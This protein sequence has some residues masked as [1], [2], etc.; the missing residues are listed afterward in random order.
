MVN[1]CD[2]IHHGLKESVLKPWQR[3]SAA[4]V[5]MVLILSL[6][7][8]VVSA[9]PGITVTNAGI[10]ATVSPGQ[11][12]TEKMTVSIGNSDPATDVSV[13]V[14]GVAQS[15]TGGYILLDPAQDTNQDT[16][17]SFVTVDPS[18]F[19]LD[20]GQSQDIT[21]IVTVPQNVGSG[22]YFA[23]INIAEPPTTTSDSNVAIVYSVG[24][25]VFLTIK[26]SQLNQ[27]GTIT[28]ITAGTI[29]NGQPINITTTFQNTGNIYFKVEGQTTITNDQGVMLDT[30]PMPLTSSSIIPGMSRDLNATFTP[31]GSLAPGTYT[32]RSVVMSSDSILLD[33]S[34]GTFTIK[35][36]YKPPPALG[37][38]SLAPSGASTLKT[39]TGNISVYFPV[40]AAAIPVD[41]S[42]NNITAAQLPVAPDGYGFTGT[43]FQ[44]NGLTGL[45][46][47][48]ATVTVQ[49]TPDD[50]SKAGGKPSSLVLTRWDPGTNKWVVLKT[51]ANAKAMTLSANSK[52]LGIMAVASSLLPS[53]GI[54]WIIIGPIVAV[55]IVIAIM[56][57]LLIARRKRVKP[58]KR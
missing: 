39:T 52:Q 13:T 46:A 10:V 26:G 5:M 53:S 24:V 50:L 23:L 16:A 45:L 1:K 36:P 7:P 29:T 44:V 6:I 40:G 54:N 4:V 47:K 58:V 55:V 34:D 17:R 33:K 22:G 8:I 56:G 57:I 21:A 2:T 15:S 30:I 3:R 37:T 51:K 38:V 18:A 27:T 11:V 12:L 19:H 42:L 43:Y 20:P 49:Y 32:I 14:T 31:S 41:I 35:A 28:G 25:P 9:N 48:N